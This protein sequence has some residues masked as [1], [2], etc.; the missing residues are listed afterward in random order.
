MS[1]Q[2]ARLP[3]SRANTLRGIGLMILGVGLLVV[4][5]ALAKYLVETYPVGQVL[6]LRHI[7][8]LLVILPYAAMGPGITSLRARNWGGQILRGLLF[9]GGTAFLIMSV[10]RLPLATVSTIT[11]SAPIFVAALSAWTIGERVSRPRWLAI[12]GGFIGV[13]IIVRPGSQ[14]FEWALMIAVATAAANG[15]RDLSTRH[16]ART[17]NSISILFWSNVIVAA[18]GLTT[19]S[20]Q[21]IPLGAGGIAGFALAGLLNAGAHFLL[22]EAMRH[23][24]AAL[25]APFRYTA[26]VWA[27]LIGFV[28]WG[29]W[30]DRWVIAGALVIAASGI[31]M[32]LFEARRQS[33]P[34]R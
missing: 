22:I 34:T 19:I 13:L 26:L 32:I 28:V 10:K 9:I 15:L 2:H 11:M 18:A 7:A 6:C 30:P 20:P 27:I 23:G 4:N 21:W 31:A 17:D 8:V 29:D 1:R 3:V 5:D 14:T 25:V 16:L 33:L 12:L 24:E